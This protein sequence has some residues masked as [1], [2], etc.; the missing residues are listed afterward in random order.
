MV[1]VGALPATANPGGQGTTSLTQTSIDP[2]L[3]QAGRYIVVMAE[4][5]IAMYDGGTPGLAP[6][7]PEAGQKL[8]ATR[9]EVQQYQAHLESKQAEVAKTENVTVKRTFTAALN[10]FSADLSAEQALALAKDPAVLAVAQDTENAPDYS[11]TD[12]LGLSGPNGS[13]NTSF[14]GVGKAGE[15]VVVGVI[16]TGYTPSSPFF[17]GEEVKPLTGEPQVGVPYR[18]ADGQIAMLKANGETFS[19]E[20]QVGTE[21]GADFD[22]TACNSKV[23]SAHYFADDF[24]KYVAPENRAPQEVLSPVDVSSHGT[25]TASTAAGNADIRATIGDRD[26]GI[27]GGVAPAAKISVYKICW[28]DN[29]PGT[30]GCYSS[31]AVAA[32]NQAI[33]DGVDVLNYSISGSTSTTTDPVSLAFLSATSAGIFV[34]AS[35]GNSGPTAGTVN[36]GAPWVTT[37]AASS[38]SSELQ[39]TAEF[40]DGTKFR[41]ASIMM[42]N[43]P[44]SP[45]LLATT[46]AAAGA[47]NPEL[48]GPNS[49]DAA[50][51]TGKVVVCDRGVIDR[52]AK[53]A[54]VKRAG[55]VGM[56]L[57]NVTVSSEDVDL[58]AVPTVHVNP[59]ATQIIKDKIAATPDIL[60]AL[61]DKD[62]TGLPV[63]PQPQIAGFSSRGPLGATGSDLLK[64]DIAAPGVA[65]LAGVSPIATGGAQ[66]GMMSGTSMAS[67]HVAGFAALLMAVN[68]TWSP[69]T[70]KS[71]MM[72]TATNVVNADGSKNNDVFATGAGQSAVAKALTP[73]LAYNA[74]DTEY[75]EFIQGTGMDLGIPDLGSTAP[76]D[77]NVASFGVGE[78]AGKV[79]VTRTVTA[80][81]PGLYRATAQVPGVNVKV[82]PSV[83][84]FSAAGD[85]RT[86]KV[87]FENVSAALGTFAMGSLSWQG[88]GATVTS[89]VAVRPMPVLVAPE[90]AFTSK[91]AKGSGNIPVVSGTNSPVNMTLDGLSKADSSAIALVPGPLVVGTNPSNVIKEVTVP[92]GTKLAK[93]QVISS[94]PNA[95]F[96]MIV[97]NPQGGFSDVRSGSSS[98][99]LS[100]ANPAPGTYTV[101]ANLYSS[102]GDTPVA[103]TIDA[104]VLGDNVGNASVSPNPL[105]LA[106]GKSGNVTLSWKG[107]KPGSYLGRVTFGDT[108]TQTFVSV[109][110]SP[111]GTAVVP[112]TEEPNSGKPIKDKKALSL[113]PDAQP[114]TDLQQ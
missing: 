100:L 104:A 37:V 33:L 113:F 8:D 62:T 65:V 63:A 42:E 16:D 94:D 4:Q 59:P 50:Q 5:P 93:F 30:G 78:L 35:A 25:H 88:A 106:N 76:R 73:G 44:P 10:G 54:E 18:T 20:C 81:K 31:S 85:Q 98:E 108:G 51:V 9:S 86:F 68:T 49:L 79:T 67:P 38:F 17:A 57:T 34:A 72:T 53:S 46:A 90:V 39:G 74:G 80:L 56:I 87:T 41:G 102:A 23:L 107:L 83:L 105:V 7:K 58:H 101:L 55:G 97:F 89:P 64:P 114:L 13:W 60:V 32:I 11:S 14:G 27:T 29:D 15:G 112:D 82:T 75:L 103:A 24:I 109:I 28:E 99:T 77:M 91:R 26:L 111:K 95:D 6:T 12:F 45:V 61:V 66:F 92:K 22:G 71:A 96:D 84:N 43:V 47:A 70:V 48:C 19:G 3:Y 2:L 21:T 110:V 1:S 52:T 69:A 36:H 40:S